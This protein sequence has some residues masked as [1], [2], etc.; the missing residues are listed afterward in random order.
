MD[1][2][3]DVEM[4][5][6]RHI[7]CGM[8]GYIMGKLFL[9]AIICAFPKPNCGRNIDVAL[10]QSAADARLPDADARLPDA[11]TRLTN[12]DARLPDARL[13]PR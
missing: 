9:E 2:D 5:V 7:A 10:P 13:E 3:M 8:A 1:N 12:A 11:D 6:F 4:D